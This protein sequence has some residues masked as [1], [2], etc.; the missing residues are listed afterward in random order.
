MAVELSKGT[1]I[2]LVSGE[3]A[4]YDLSGFSAL[5]YIEVGEVLS[6]P[7]FGGSANVTTR[8]P[9]G[10]GIVDKR[11]GSIDYGSSQISLT[12]DYTDV[13][14]AAVKSGFDG[15]NKGNV[16]SFKIYN[17]DI[18]T[19]YFTGLVMSDVINPDN[20]DAFF[21]GGFTIEINNSIVTTGGTTFYTFTYIA[22]TNGAIIGPTSQQVASG[23]DGSAVY[24]SAD[25]SYEFSAWSDASTDNPRTD[26]SAAAN[27]SLTASFVSS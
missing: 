12:K 6:I 15:A 20:A 10:T 5:T 3:P 26:T 7:E 18:G 22:G 13:G 25:A 2:S 27:L 17:A 21:S 11:A 14:Q 8:T 16:H 9:I 19:I 1:T 4:T 24:A 23:A